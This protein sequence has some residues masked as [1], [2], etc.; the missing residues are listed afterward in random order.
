MDDKLSPEL[1]FCCLVAGRTLFLNLK[2]QFVLLQLLASHRLQSLAALPAI[3]RTCSFPSQPQGQLLHTN[4]NSRCTHLL[5]LF[6]I[7]SS[8][9][10]LCFLSGEKLEFLPRK[11]ILKAKGWLLQKLPPAPW[12]GSCPGFSGM[13]IV[14]F[15]TTRQCIQEQGP[16]SQPSGRPFWGLHMRCTDCVL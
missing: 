16:S 7:P 4:C 6:L 14:H 11:E 3:N 12:R 2:G 8:L 1:S 9:Q 10:H 15:L 13:R 5:G